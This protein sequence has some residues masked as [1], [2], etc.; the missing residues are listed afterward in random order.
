MSLAKIIRKLTETTGTFTCTTLTGRW[1]TYKTDERAFQQQ[2]VSF[3]QLVVGDELF[4]ALERHLL[5]QTALSAEYVAGHGLLEE[6]N[7]R[8]M[9]FR[10]IYQIFTRCFD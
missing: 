3:L 10:A 6:V 4:H 1:A 9:H 7:K 8:Q 2:H 5:D